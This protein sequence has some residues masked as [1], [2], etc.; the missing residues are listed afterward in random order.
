MSASFRGLSKSAI[1]ALAAL[2]LIAGCK[3]DKASADKGLTVG[4]VSDVAGRGDQSFNDSALRGLEL[5]AA[6]KEYAGGGYQVATPKTLQASIPPE[7]EDKGIHK[8]PIQPLVLQSNSQEDYEPNLQLL[9]DKGAKLTIGTGFMLEN[10]V[11]SVAKRNPN[12]QFLLID[13]RLL[14]AKG[15]PYSL[16][17]VRTVTF[18]EEEGSFLAGALA[19]LVTQTGKVAFV[20]G[21]EIPLIRKFEAGFRAGLAATNPAAAKSILVNYT[22]SFDNAGTGKQ[23][24]QDLLQKGADVVFHAAGSDGLGVIQAVKEAHSAGKAVYAI[25]VD[26]DQWHLAPK[27]V[28]T[29]M[30]KHVDLAVYDAVR[31]LVENKFHGGDQTLGLKEGGVGLAPVRIDFPGKADAMKKVDALR[32]E[33]ISGK[34]QVP[35]TPGQS[36]KTPAA[37]KAKP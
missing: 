8:L 22:G 9:V 15:T 30:V 12:A 11:E 25:G 26:S 21:M 34:I 4:L 27:S 1:A 3:R 37:E 36:E 32:E 7:L 2:L 10:A 19:G 6:G 18:K 33:I 35:S 16:P 24:T 28:L 13:S 20:G 29:S 31:D 14:D 17:N 23:V 5:W